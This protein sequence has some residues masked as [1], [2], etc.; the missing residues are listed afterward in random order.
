MIYKDHLI[1]LPNQFRAGLQLKQIIKATVYP[2][3][4]LL[5]ILFWELE[6]P[7]AAVGT[8][9]QFGLHLTVS[10]MDVMNSPSECC[11]I[12]LWCSGLFSLPFGTAGSA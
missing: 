6:P 3:V 1:Q 12:L 11:L 9:G 10:L 8:R 7:R 2:T 5:P 4:M